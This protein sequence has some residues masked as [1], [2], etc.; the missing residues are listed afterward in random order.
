MSG[1]DYCD[2]GL[3]KEDPAPSR[4]P[5]GGWHLRVDPDDYEPTQRIPCMLGPD[6]KQAWTMVGKIAALIEERDNLLA[7][8]DRL[9]ARLREIAEM[10]DG[11]IEQ[12][13]TE[14]DAWVFARSDDF[15]TAHGIARTALTKEDG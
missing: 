15:V 13:G 6:E 3:P 8:R 11:D 12:D 9:K 10:Y 4:E 1:C 7:E 14:S 5:P 2:E